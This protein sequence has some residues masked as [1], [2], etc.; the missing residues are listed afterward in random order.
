MSDVPALSLALLRRVADFLDALPEDQISDLAEGRARLT[1]IPWGATA[2]VVPKAS[3]RTPARKAA[4]KVDASAM[5]ANLSVAQ[6]RDEG[7]SLLGSL[8]VTDLRAV[9]TAVGMTGVSKTPKD[10]LLEQIV[11]LTIGGRASFAAM[12]DL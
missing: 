2:P 4:S 1:Y 6:T 11:A 12:R 10:A 5:A 8:S 9:A 3:R 7:R